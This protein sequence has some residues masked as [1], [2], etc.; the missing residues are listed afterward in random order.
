VACLHYASYIMGEPTTTAAHN[1]R[2]RWANN[3]YL[4]PD[5][6]AISLQPPVV[7][8]PGVQSAGAAVDDPTLQSAVEDTINQLM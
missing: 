4:Q 6:V 5:Q 2:L 1:T 7:M 8:D 3:C